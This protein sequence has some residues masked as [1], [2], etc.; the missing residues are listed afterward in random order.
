[1]ATRLVM[2]CT[3]SHPRFEVSKKVQQ[4]RLW[5]FHLPTCSVGIWKDFR[6]MSLTAA[7][8]AAPPGM[9]ALTR[10]LSVDPQG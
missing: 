2:S 7:Q 8:L 6:V 5:P 1:M 3:H 9:S 10:L 4:H